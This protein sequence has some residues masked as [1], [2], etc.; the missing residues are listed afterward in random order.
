VNP[1]SIKGHP[2]SQSQHTTLSL[3]KMSSAP[4]SLHSFLPVVS[5]FTNDCA[6]TIIAE[7]AGIR[8]V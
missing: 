8:S 6:H 4:H 7:P 1:G 5:L 3:A 2:P